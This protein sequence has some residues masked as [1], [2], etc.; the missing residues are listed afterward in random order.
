MTT[1]RFGT[2]AVTWSLPTRVLL[3]SA[4]LVPVVLLV[5]AL[6]SIA[7]YEAGGAVLL[8]VAGV[9]LCFVP[10]YLAAVWQP[11]PG[12]HSQR[13]A[14]LL[15]DAQVAERLAKQLPITPA[16]A[17]PDLTH[18]SMTRRRW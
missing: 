18:T 2:S 4:A 9:S 11:R 3:T 17:P 16:A 7:N 10:R 5:V 13:R 6:L 14:E 1:N 12:W 8:P 15:R